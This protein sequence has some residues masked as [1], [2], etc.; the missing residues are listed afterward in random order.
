V[1]GILI[2]IGTW[3]HWMLSAEL[4]PAMPKTVA[5]VNKNLQEYWDLMRLMRRL[6]LAAS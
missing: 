2:A 1:S 6:R 4:H 3:V 5:D